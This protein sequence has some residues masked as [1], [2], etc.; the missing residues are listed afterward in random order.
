M[1]D[2][3]FDITQREIVLSKGSHG[4][5]V[6]TSNPSVQNGGM[7]LFS[8]GCNLSNPMMGIGIEEIVN[9]GAGAPTATYEMNRW[10][11]QVALDGGKATW[12]S[13][14]SA[15]NNFDFTGNVDY[16]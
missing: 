7:L 5:F 6:T 16:L 13:I 1:M 10:K 3:L 11:A 12:S 8:R 4:D 9:A 14:P 2:L 15:N